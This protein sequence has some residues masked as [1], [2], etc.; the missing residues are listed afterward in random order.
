MAKNAAEIL[1]ET[2]LDWGVDTIFGIPGDGVNGIIEALRQNRERIRFIQ[3]RHEESAAFMACAWAKFTGK[4]GVCIA[5]SG[6]GGIHLLNGLY[7]AKMDGQPVLAITGMQFHDLIGTQTQQDVALDKLYIDVCVY[8]ERVMGAAHMQNVAELACR[9]AMSRR[10]VAHIT[11][12]VDLQEQKLEDDERSERNRA[13]H[14]SNVRARSAHI[15][16]LDELQQAAQV[17]KAGKKVVILAGRGALNASDEL[18]Q[19]AELLGRAHRQGAAWQGLCFGRQPLHYGWHWSASALS[20]RRMRSKPATCCS[21][22]VRP[23]PTL[24]SIRNRERRAPCRSISIPPASGS[25]IRWKWDWWAIAPPRCARLIPL[26]ERNQDRSFLKKA[27]D[28]MKEWRELMTTRGTDASTPLKPDVVAYELGK[29]LSAEAIVT[30]DSGTITTFWARQIPA[31]RGQMHSCS[32]NLATMACGLP[33][34]IAAQI[35]YPN[36]QVVAFVGDG[37]FTMLMGELATCMKYKLPIKIVIIKNN[38][39]GQIRWEQ[40][41]FLGNPEY[42]CD[43]Q[44]IDFAAVAR[45]F[46]ASSFVIDDP[47][48]CGAI[49]D[50]ALATDGP[51]VIE[52]VVDPNTPPLPAKIKAKQALHLAEALVRGEKDAAEIVKSIAGG[53]VRELV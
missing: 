27:Q 7:D 26:L 42:V 29:R 6:P 48:R 33:Y 16:A 12:P 38:T 53:K 45:G 40:M 46:G 3:V 50:Q 13:G 10:G 18:E 47:K 15:P 36:R 52:A 9:T 14:V 19:V 25:A 8:N 4:L 11:M 44:P 17:L 41:V 20:L 30:S 22:R 31:K 51:V 35:A 37:G 32:G 1:V 34:A 2:L 39:L 21:S 28:S 49:L 24:S 23:S 5:T 43:L